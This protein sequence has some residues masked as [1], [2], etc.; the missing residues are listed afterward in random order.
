M[1]LVAVHP[2][3][4]EERQQRGVEVDH[5]H[6][7]EA[8]KEDRR[9]DVVE[10]RQHD[11][12]RADTGDRLRH[13]HVR[14]GAVGVG[15]QREDRARNARERGALERGHARVIGDDDRDARVDRVAGAG[16]EDR[17]QVRAAT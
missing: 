3:T 7:R 8:D 4:A 15:A 2:A 6:A 14:R 5:R 17:L 10:A 1:H 11:E 13:R 9:E 16:V 12:L